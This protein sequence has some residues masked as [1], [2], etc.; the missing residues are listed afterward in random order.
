M[1]APWSKEM[2]EMLINFYTRQSIE[3]PL[4]WQQGKCNKASSGRWLIHKSLFYP[5]R[6]IALPTWHMLA[7]NRHVSFILEWPHPTCKTLKYF[8]T[9][10]ST[11]SLLNLVSPNWSCI[12]MQCLYRHTLGF[13]RNALAYAKFNWNCTK[14]RKSVLRLWW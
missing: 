14:T 5:V 8:W 12:L 10:T 11:N 2:T 4:I 3:A 1:L 9:L 6:P 13:L 7:F